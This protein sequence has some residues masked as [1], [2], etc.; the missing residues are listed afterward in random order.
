MPIFLYIFI[1]YLSIFIHEIGHYSAAYLFGIKATDVVTGMGIKIFSFKTRSTHFIFNLIP[2]GGVTIY[3]TKDQNKLNKLQQIIILLAG[4]TFNYLIAIIA[5]TL[6]YQT[7]LITGLKILNILIAQF[8][9]S[10][11][12]MLTINDFLTPDTSFTESINV[13]AS[14]ITLSQFTLFLFLFMN[15]LLFLF[16]FIPIPFFDGGQIISILF[17]PLLFKLGISEDYLE[18]I[19]TL[20]NKA[21]GYFLLFL[22]IIPFV[23]RWYHDIMRSTNPKAELLKWIL[24]LL[25]AIL[26]KRIF[27]T[28]KKLIRANKI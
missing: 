4:G 17:D 11:T 16:N 3:D 10:L 19:K 12:S 7:N 14:E 6:Y 23:N 28:L 20:I 26:I 13:I 5:S 18:L 21:T 1:A 2:S 25:G 24:I 15:V 8:I 9:K 22:I 27:S